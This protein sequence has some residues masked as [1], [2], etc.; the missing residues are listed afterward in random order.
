MIII[1]VVLVLIIA[2]LVWKFVIPM[3]SLSK[4]IAKAGK[5]LFRSKT[6]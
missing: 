5:K 2:L 6:P 1:I 4:D 3:V